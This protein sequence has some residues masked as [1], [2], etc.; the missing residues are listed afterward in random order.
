[1]DERSDDTDGSGETPPA[2]PEVTPDPEPPLASP[3]PRG[4]LLRSVGLGTG[5]A[6]SA[7]VSAA[8]L[9]TTG[10]AWWTVGDLSGTT[11]TTDVIDHEVADTRIPLDG[12]VDMLLVGMDSRTDANGN[13]LPREVMDMLHAGVNEGER[14]TD[15][16]ILVHIPVDG[17]RA[18][19]ISFPRDSWVQLAGGFGRHKLNSAFAY[20]YNDARRDLAR[21]ISDRKALETQAATVGRRNLIETIETLIGKAVTIDRYAEVNLASFYEITKAIGGVEVCLNEAVDERRSGANFPAGR[22]TVEGAAALA[23][24]RQRYELPNGDLDRI[25]R[26]QV[27]LGA[28]ADKVLSADMLTS[29]AKIRELVGAVQRS[30]VLSNGWELFTFAAQMQGLTSGNIDFYT[31]PTQGAAKIGGAD[32]IRVDPAEV[33]QFVAGLVGAAGAGAEPSARP[34]FTPP[35]GSTTTTTR[36]SRTTPTQVPPRAGPSEFDPPPLQQPSSI[37]VDVR[38]GSGTAGLAATVADRLV[39]QGFRR[40]E[41]AESPAQAVTVIRYASG[42]QYSAQLVASAL[43]RQFGLEMDL[44]LPAGRVRVLLGSDY[45][46]GSAQGKVLRQPTTP[47]TPTTT[48]PV[49]PSPIVAGSLTCVN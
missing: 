13:P 19:A 17:T 42:E 36:P 15:T 35:S 11:V 25:V 26:Q 23:F 39:G 37:T 43:G 9:A 38:N 20:A 18:V 3:P 12:A 44:S 34:D 24:V 2:E 41:I 21:T 31:I 5:R 48:E 14:N 7:V 10:Y 27:F 45:P 1:M 33:H 49:L 6:M 40:G 32:V 46:S 28:L 30:V 8:V 4:N 29:P 47:S 22:Q 16:M